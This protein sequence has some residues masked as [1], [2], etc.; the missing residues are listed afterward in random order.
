MLEDTK[1]QVWMRQS[2]RDPLTFSQWVYVQHVYN[3]RLA[4]K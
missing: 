3:D 2:T 1:A 4:K